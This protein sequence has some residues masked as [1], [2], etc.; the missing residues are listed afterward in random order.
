MP[1]L[2][3]S[4]G[5]GMV[6]LSGVQDNVF[7]QRDSGPVRVS[8]AAELYKSGFYPDTSFRRTG[9]YIPGG[10]GIYRK[11]FKPG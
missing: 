9:T 10:T 1:C 8:P 2:R 5:N 11:S 3:G 7:S 4:N 6:T